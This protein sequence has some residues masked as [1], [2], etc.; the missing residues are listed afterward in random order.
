M[1]RARGSETM[2]SPTGDGAAARDGA[3]SGG[4][5]GRAG[6]VVWLFISQQPALSATWWLH[7][8]AG[9]WH[10][11]CSGVQSAASGAA[12][13]AA[14]TST[15]ARAPHLVRIFSRL[16]ADPVPTQKSALLRAS[17]AGK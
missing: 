1:C 9:L 4:R 10:A 3:T 13:I 11:I 7:A 15:P 2:A 16:E 8:V 6:A 5:A 14:T 17:S 12:I